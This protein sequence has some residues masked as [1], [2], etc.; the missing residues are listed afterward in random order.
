M[1]FECLSQISEKQYRALGSLLS[2]NLAIQPGKMSVRKEL[3]QV[4]DEACTQ[5]PNMKEAMTRLDGREYLIIMVLEIW[6]FTKKA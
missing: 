1:N 2:F 6:N 3:G 4:V 5:V